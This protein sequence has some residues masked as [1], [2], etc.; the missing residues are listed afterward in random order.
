[1]GLGTATSCPP[2]P[3]DKLV[4]M[5]P[6]RA[7][8]PADLMRESTASSQCRP[9]QTMRSPPGKADSAVTASRCRAEANRD[10]PACNT[11]D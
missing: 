9:L 8:A 5:V 7:S 6:D 10:M 2:I 3:Q 11:D 4:Q 1:M